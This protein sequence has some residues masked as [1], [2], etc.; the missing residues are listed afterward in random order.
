MK[1]FLKNICFFVLIILFCFSLFAVGEE[2]S[3]IELEKKRAAIESIISRLTVETSLQEIAV[4]RKE[5]E[6]IYSEVQ[7]RIGEIKEEIA[8]FNLATQQKSPAATTAKSPKVENLASPEIQRSKE[9]KE[10]ELSEYK[11]L[12][13]DCQE[14]LDILEKARKKRLT[15]NLIH[16]GESLVAVVQHAV[17]SLPQGAEPGEIWRSFLVEEEKRVV[18]CK[19]DLEEIAPGYFFM[20]PPV[21]VLILILLR[22]VVHKIVARYG[23]QGNLLYYFDSFLLSRGFLPNSFIALSALSVV[24]SWFYLRNDFFSLLFCW[25]VF[26]LF[27]I[28]TAPVG[29]RVLAG[30]LRN[31]KISA[32]DLAVSGDGQFF[33]ALFCL[34]ITVLVLYASR[35]F[36]CIFPPEIFYILRFLLLVISLTA[37][38]WVTYIVRRKYIKSSAGRLLLK[39]VV[40]GVLLLIVLEGAGYRN[41]MDYLL[42]GACETII[43]L[44]LLLF[45]NDLIDLLIR[46]MA[47]VSDSALSR[48]VGKEE[49]AVAPPDN[50]LRM[51]RFALK[52]VLYLVFCYL[53]IAVWGAITQAGAVAQVF[54]QGVQFGG[55]SLYPARLVA[56]L[57]ILLVGFTAMGFCKQLISWFWLRH[58]AISHNSRETILTLTGYLGYA[59]LIFVALNIAG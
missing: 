16:R 52:L 56:G 28:I 33:S 32:Q 12:L 59:L 9:E 7:R 19:D 17:N 1:H 25:A 18:L 4:M 57:V 48:F 40:P 47:A 45:F 22:N 23:E 51:L 34:L 37:L 30:R 20:L 54:S 39:I 31:S 14:K 53:L 27:Y 29:L 44:G 55:F 10:A 13:F 58:T 24:V 2:R 5:I 11:L 26:F 6:K 8:Q 43:L 41:L 38:V 49:E 15:R 42:M 21:L 3:D 36:F 46:C 35:V 50:A